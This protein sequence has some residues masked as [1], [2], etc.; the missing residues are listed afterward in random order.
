MTEFGLI[1][2]IRR[3]FAAIPRNGFDGIGDDC[4]ALPLG[5]G[6]SLVF[7]TDLLAENIHFLRSATSPRELGGKALAVNLSDVAA[8][9]ARPV[10]TLLS[11]AI[12]RDLPDGWIEAFMEGY[13][14]LSEQHAVG[15]VGGDTT[16]SDSGL[17]I[18]VTAIGRVADRCIKRR[19]DALPGD[20]IAVGGP[21]GESGAG[22]QDILAGRCDTP[23][24][25]IHR[26]PQPQVEEGIW[27]G[28]RPEV[29]A[30]MDISDGIASDLRHILDRSGVGAQIDIESI[31]TSVAVETAVS[32]G[33]DYKLL[34]TFAA[35]A[36]DTLARDYATRFDEGFHVIGR[37]TPGDRLEWLLDGVPRQVDWQG[38]RHY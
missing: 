4:T 7:T 22:L 34:F 3:M 9:G 30:M 26:N 23:L 14:T 18:N 28:R 37:I 11:L 5:D 12:P 6:S 17:V 31:P 20:L 16:A 8:M 15:L 24:A 19:S 25:R 38:F 13:R 35:E 33:E 10:A 36:A 29:H 27:L 2:T 32:G 21:L 1:D